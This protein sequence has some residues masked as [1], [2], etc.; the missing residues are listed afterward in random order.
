MKLKGQ[1]FVQ[2]L[3]QDQSACDYD[4][5]RYDFMEIRFYGDQVIYGHSRSKYGPKAGDLIWMLRVNGVL[6]V[7]RF[8]G[9][10]GYGFR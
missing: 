5:N 8:L 2:W 7:H 4:H 6:L 9:R 3:I 1:D 10:L